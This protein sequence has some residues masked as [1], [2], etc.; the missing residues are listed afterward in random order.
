MTVPLRVL[1]LEDREA[2][3]ALVLHELRQAGFDPVW[4]RVDDE[5]GFLTQLESPPD[6]ICADYY[7]PQFDAVRALA[8]IKERG[9]D[10]PFII[11]SG[12]IGEELAVAAMRQGATDYLL[13]DRL[14]RL[15]PAVQQA[16]EQKRLRYE[17]RQ[18]DQS[19]KNYL[20]MLAHELRNPLAP[21][22]T[23]LEVARQGATAT[24][25]QQQAL[26]TMGR[27]VRHL[28][29]LVDDLLEATRVNQGR[30]QLRTDRVDLAQVARTAGEDRRRL[31]EQVSLQL[32][33]ATPQTPMWV[34]GDETRL[35][36]CL[37]N[38]LDNACRFTDP[39]GSVQLTART[40]AQQGVIAVQDTGIGME[41]ELLTSLFRPFS[42]GDRSLERSRGGLGLGLSIVKTLVE[43]HGG[44]VEATSA[45]PGRGATFTLRL[46]QE[47]EPPALTSAPTEHGA[48]QQR[49]K[50]LIIE[51]NRDAAD[52]L[53]LLLELL[54]QEVR[55]AYTG[56]EGV[57]MATAWGPNLVLCDI[58]L[59]GMDGF[60]V[61]A[62]L[63][64]HPATARARIVAITGYGSE[65]DRRRA[66]EAGFD[67][68][69]RKP[70]EPGD[71]E[72]AIARGQGAQ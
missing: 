43:A 20:S 13:K 29:R 65:E 28:A 51:D 25:T 61:S 11:V 60:G 44:T 62:A 56:P 36:Q 49:L 53:K 1:I 35:A 45:G 46:P 31:F 30:I 38:L 37:H 5:A 47:P 17:K 67:L 6:L 26:D 72:E 23:S 70:V 10:I 40:E 59:P 21:L 55:V 33:V 3:A 69:L 4:Q 22:L 12:S 34:T 42:Q 14:A 16:L 2:D 64:L 19:L 41:P 54:G 63:R 48:T 57:A 32:T 50:I 27:A 39:G 66:R 15:G 9:L 8:L 58:G 18:M 68:L 71:L 7:M 52:S 24:E